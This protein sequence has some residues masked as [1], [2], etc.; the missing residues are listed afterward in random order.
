[1]LIKS[2]IKKD[3]YISFSCYNSIYGKNKKNY[4]KKLIN[5]NLIHLIKLKVKIFDIA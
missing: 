1:M 3:K 5:L 2:F 4:F